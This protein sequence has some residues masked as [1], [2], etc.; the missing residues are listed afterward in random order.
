MYLIQ[1]LMN[2][3][4]GKSSYIFNRSSGGNKWGISPCDNIL[5]TSSNIYSLMNWESSK[6]SVYACYSIPTSL[7]TASNYSSQYLESITYRDSEN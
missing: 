3:L 7:S 4:Y 6:N 1:F 5:Q 2:S